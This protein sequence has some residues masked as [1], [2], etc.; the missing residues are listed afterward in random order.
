MDNRRREN[1]QYLLANQIC[2]E[3]RLGGGQ[4]VRMMKRDRMAREKSRMALM[5]F[6]LRPDCKGEKEQDQRAEGKKRPKLVQCIISYFDFE[7][8]QANFISLSLRGR[9]NCAKNG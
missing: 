9:K 6:F 1:S 2:E 5:S 4:L 7:S 3:K 8:Q